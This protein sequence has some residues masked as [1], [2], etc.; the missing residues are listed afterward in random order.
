[1]PIEEIK[2]KFLRI[3]NKEHPTPRY[4]EKLD[5]IYD[6]IKNAKNPIRIKEIVK[7]T[8]INENTI[9]TYIKYL[10]KERYVK[11]T[12]TY[13]P[14]FLLIEHLK[15]DP[16]FIYGKDKRENRIT[17]E[18]NT[19]LENL[20]NE[21]N[22]TY[23]KEIDIIKKTKDYNSKFFKAHNKIVENLWK[24]NNKNVSKISIKS[25]ANRYKIY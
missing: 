25:G 2:K 9:R 7:I 24:K 5:N 19:L 18:K 13:T 17:E 1:M 16:E 3:F 20:N 8:S 23:N 21:L 12:K 6:T 4:P 15:E 11:K 10:E 14:P 22:K